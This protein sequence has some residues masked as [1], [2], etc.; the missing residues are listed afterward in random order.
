M[1]DEPRS[2]AI[3]HGVRGEPPS[4]VDAL[5]TCLLRLSQLAVECPEVVELDINPLFVYPQSQGAA[6]ADVR[7]RI[8]QGQRSLAKND[9]GERVDRGTALGGARSE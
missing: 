5:V 9:G 2:S 8:G 7:V 6:V 3:L 4:D 1:V